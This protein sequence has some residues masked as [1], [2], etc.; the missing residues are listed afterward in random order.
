[1]LNSFQISTASQ[2][3]GHWQW[4]VRLLR[5]VLCGLLF[6]AGSVQAQ[7]LSSDAFDK[8]G[9][10]VPKMDPNGKIHVN[11][12][13]MTADQET[14]LAVLQGNVLITFSDITMTCD[15]ATYDYQTGDIHAEGNIDI[16][17]QAGG[18]WQGDTIDFNH[19][20][21]RGLIG[22]GLLRLGEFAVLADSIARDEDGIAYSKNATITTCTNDTSAWHWS[23]KGA[24]RY[25][26]KE[27]LEL[28]DAVF[29]LFGIP[30]MWAPYYYRDL[31]S[32]YGWRVMPGFS[33]KWGAY[34]LTGYVYPIA[35]SPEDD[36]LLYGKTAVDLRS[37][38]GIAAGQ[39]LTWRTLGGVFGEDTIQ[40]G[41]VS[42]YVARHNEDLETENLNW[43]SP[44]ND[45][46]YSFG[47]REWIDF[48]PR[49]F[50]SIEGEYVS[51]SEF[52][53][54]YKE[55]SVRD[56][57]EPV[58]IANY[59]HRENTW[60]NSL[61]IGGPLNSFYAGTR[62]LPEFRLD[63][64]PKRVFDI[65]ELYYESQ[66]T[67]GWYERQA[68]KNR[69][70]SMKRYSYRPGN[71]A[72]FESLRLDTRHMFRR[73][74][75]LTDGVTLTPRLGW[76]GTY[77][78]DSPDNDALFRSLFEMGIT[79]QARYW[80]DFETM[81]HTV[82]P[83]VDFTYVPGS[84]EGPEDQSYAFDRID[85]EYE[86]RDRFASDGLTPTHRYS[87]VRF[88]VRNLLQRRAKDNVLTRYLNVD[89]YSVYVA[90]TQDHWVRWRH[91]EQPGRDNL[92]KRAQRV[93]EPTGFRI[94]GLDTA[95]SPTRYFDIVSDIQYDPEEGRLAFWD[96]G[97]RAYTKKVTYYAGYLRRDHD[98]Y[99]YY[100]TDPVQDALIYGGFL[101]HVC[102]TFDWS[103]YA[104]YNLE[105]NDLEEIGGF[106]QYNLDCMSFRFN[107]EFQPSY[108]S[109]D[110][111]KHDSDLKLSLGMWLRAFPK[112]EDDLDW[113]SWGNLTNIRKLQR[114]KE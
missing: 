20:T 52:R 101:H 90:Q 65:P 107:V 25:K 5:G 92:R 78:S 104:R 22:A 43:Q 95:F 53:S 45:Y 28:R 114:P 51:D 47:L 89:L 56:A 58:G 17:S 36:A 106:L 67:V 34:L 71:W 75:S 110:E 63:T 98:L 64:L 76:R 3:T 48:S 82:I 100:W 73:P 87:G 1:M 88:G 2:T 15:R 23:V 61:S 31:N 68:A 26:D 29:H 81:R 113:M 77:Y 105:Y 9:F 57:S 18:S 84:Q 93:K 111:Y 83:Y 79:L 6:V 60:V 112:E 96:I 39:E 38:Y 35:G 70:A 4:A 97:V 103:L 7:S 46:R 19:K 54:D 102:D 10:S 108:V 33:S 80:K 27:F 72:Y 16:Y 86:W 21:G 94:L 55:I 40:Q 42:A 11:A 109:E 50:I 37:K 59:E 69:G 14:G 91:R 12:D 74:F 49:D 66:T 8:I 24:V 41:R 85:Q 44:Y 32:H 62:R 99:D 30:V 13:K